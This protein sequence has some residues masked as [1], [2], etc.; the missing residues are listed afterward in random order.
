MASTNKTANYELS[1]FLGS[2]KPA[3]LGDYNTD[4]SKI[5]AQMKLNA[6]KATGADGKADSN[7]TAIGTLAS[8]TTEEKTNL[9]GAINEVDS[10]ADTAQGTANDASTTAGTALLTANQ[11]KNQFNFT[12]ADV[13]CSLSSGSLD[14]NNKTLHVA[15]NSDGSI[16]KIY[17]RLRYN[18]NPGATLTCTS[19]DTGLRPTTDITFEGCCLR[20]TGAGTGDLVTYQTYTLHTNGTVTT[21]FSAY[22]G[23]TRMDILFMANVLFITDFGDIPLPE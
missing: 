13:T 17:G 19:G 20:I 1:Q 15:K 9:V 10:H 8:L 2:D 11:V 3:W 16:A 12:Y 7:A 23:A 14:A 21:E 22:S 5:D 6:D 18:G 4:M